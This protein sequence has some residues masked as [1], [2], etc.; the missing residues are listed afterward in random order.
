[1]PYY[2]PYYNYCPPGYPQNYSS[3]YPQN[4]SSG[5]QQSVVPYPSYNFPT[6]TQTYPSY[7][8]YPNNNAYKVSFTTVDAPNGED[9]S[10]STANTTLKFLDGSNIT[11]T[12][13]L[14]DY[15]VTFGLNEDVTLTGGSLTL[16]DT[17]D[18]ITT[19]VAVVSIIAAGTIATSAVCVRISSVGA[20]GSVILQA[21]TVDGQHLIILNEGAGIITF[22]TTPAVSNFA[23]T[24][25]ALQIQSAYH[26]VWNSFDSRWYAID[27]L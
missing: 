6:Y 7:P 11:I 2:P 23:K 14:S 15:S 24:T 20:V 10:A 22:D 17:S 16:T 25:A 19:P 4:Y 9:F 18:F 8:S 3:G 5:Y 27:E 13:K 12:G 1:M 21:G 26:F